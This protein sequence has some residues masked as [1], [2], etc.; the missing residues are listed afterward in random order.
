MSW[1]KPALADTLRRDPAYPEVTCR[2]N[3]RRNSELF[4]TRLEAAVT[5]M[6]LRMEGGYEPFDEWVRRPQ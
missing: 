6:V 4:M 2:E 3:N 1:V 5:H